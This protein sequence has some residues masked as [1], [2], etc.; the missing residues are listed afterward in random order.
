MFDISNGQ[1]TP[2]IGL[3][4][5]RVGKSDLFYILA[6]TPTKLYQFVDVILNKDDKPIFQ[7]IFNNYLTIP[8]EPFFILFYFLNYFLFNKYL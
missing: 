7:Q 8:G 5:Y 3:Q 4:Y 6:I 1:P 2:I